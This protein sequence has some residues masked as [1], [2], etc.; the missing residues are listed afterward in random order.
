[1]AEW[2]GAGARLPPGEVLRRHR[3]EAQGLCLICIYPS[4]IYH[5]TFTDSSYPLF[6]RGAGCYVA[7]WYCCRII[8]CFMLWWLGC[9]LELDYCVSRRLNF[10]DCSSKRLAAGWSVMSC[11]W[12][13]WWPKQLQLGC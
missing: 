2:G 6:A 4:Q 3:Q 10:D 1:V 8:W 5:K 11:V 7:H 9:N 12:P 13:I